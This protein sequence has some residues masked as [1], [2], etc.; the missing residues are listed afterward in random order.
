MR[1]EFTRCF[2]ERV[3][4]RNTTHWTTRIAIQ[5]APT[6]RKPHS[7]WSMLSSHAPY[8][9]RRYLVSCK[10][11]LIWA[12]GPPSGLT[13]KCS[14]ALLSSSALLQLASPLGCTLALC[15]STL[16]LPSLFFHLPSAL[17]LAIK[18]SKQFHTLL[19]LAQWLLCNTY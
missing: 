9:P 4:W 8:S 5:H 11:Y 3:T 6:A 10:E 7:P 12:V 1:E 2:G 13:S 17:P 18:T 16:P 14:L 19:F 15:H